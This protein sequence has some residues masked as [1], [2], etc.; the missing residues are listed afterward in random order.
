MIQVNNIFIMK[1][2]NNE[3]KRKIGRIEE[4]CKHES[5]T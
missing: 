5:S 1:G 4:I 2:D 3:F